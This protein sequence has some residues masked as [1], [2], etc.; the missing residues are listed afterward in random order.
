MLRTFAVALLAIA[1]SV[2]LAHAASSFSL[3]MAHQ[4]HRHT[5]PGCTAGQQAAA[6]CS[7]G[8]A[9][10]GKPLLC[11]KGQWCHYPFMNVCTQ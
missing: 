11:Q 9:A 10:N 6:T 5:I 4:W 7:C 3:G 2:G 1:M 8:T